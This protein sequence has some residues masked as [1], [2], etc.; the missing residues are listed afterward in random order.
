M[1]RAFAFTLVHSTSSTGNPEISHQLTEEE[2]SDL[3]VSDC[4]SYDAF[5]KNYST[6][7]SWST[8]ICNC[9]FHSWSC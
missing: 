5:L 2:L 1:L 7:F 8:G 6:N 4:K 9:L 3:A